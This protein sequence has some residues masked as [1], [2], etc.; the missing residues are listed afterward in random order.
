MI[1]TSEQ[2]ESRLTSEGNIA[3]SVRKLQSAEIII[4]D[5]KNNKEGRP[6]S[7]NLTDAEKV[8]IGVL[9]KTVG[10]ELASEIMGVQES[11]ARH[12][13]SAQM[14][15]S[16]GRGTQRGGINQELKDK[17]Q[18]RI[19]STK[20]T[21]SER[22]AEK[23]LAAM[24]MI[25]EDKLENVSAKDAAQISNQ[26]SQVLRNMTNVNNNSGERGKTNVKIVLHQPKEASETSF[27]IIEFEN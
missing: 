27:D 5:G 6:G 26:M 9:A 22:A 20:L 15:I 24:G 18:E 2:L 3:E 21:I 8:A 7:H 17:I 10:N 1:L 19:D 25:T 4:K 14:T 12:L 16:D 23:L 13:R 11:T